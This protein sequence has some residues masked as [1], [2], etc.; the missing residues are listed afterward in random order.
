LQLK[1]SP[2]F[3]YIQLGQYVWQDGS[4]NSSF[5]VKGAGQYWVKISDEHC[6]SIDTIIVHAKDKPFF[7][8]PDIWKCKGKEVF[9]TVDMTDTRFSWNDG[10]TGGSRNI[11]Q[12]GK[13]A[14]TAEN[15]C[16]AYTDVFT[17]TELPELKL[18]LGADITLCRDV[19]VVLN[20]FSPSASYEWSDGSL[21]PVKTIDKPG[22]YWVNVFNQCSSLRD[23]ID[24]QYLKIESI[25]IPNVIT[26][27]GDNFN[28]QFVLDA[29]LN[30]PP[31]SIVNRWGNLVYSSDH[32]KNDWQGGNVS[33][34][35]YYY[36]IRDACSNENIKGWI[37]VIK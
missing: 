37:H 22:T 10:F 36:T 33:A 35:Y 23:T 3:P 14:I 5:T 25:N 9:I 8:Q 31:I 30:N 12:P 29:S 18:D 2:T 15:A 6:T 19:P 24:I 16:G 7:D 20:V 13:Y 28:E 11:V 27:N 21:D 32:Y 4:L 34:G 17:V 26:P 1:V